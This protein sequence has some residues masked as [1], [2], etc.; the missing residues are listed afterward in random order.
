MTKINIILLFLIL[1]T[2]SVRAKG[3]SGMVTAEQV[4]KKLGLEPLPG[5]GGYFVQ[6]HK[7]RQ[8]ITLPDHPNNPRSAST[9][10]YYLV[11]PESF[12]ALHRLT[13]DEVFH[14]YGGDPV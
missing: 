13:Q 9:A 2:L 7:D 10:I 14:F 5:E 6:T 11:T 8:Q 4:I 12:S 3:E 1:S